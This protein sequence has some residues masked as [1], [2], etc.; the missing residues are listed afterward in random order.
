M[1]LMHIIKLIP[2]SRFFCC[3]EMFKPRGLYEEPDPEIN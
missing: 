2:P 1:I 3:S